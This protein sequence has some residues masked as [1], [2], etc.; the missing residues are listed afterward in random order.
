[1]EAERQRLRQ[2][3]SAEMSLIL[4]IGIR[5]AGGKKKFDRLVRAETN[6]L[7]KMGIPQNKNDPFNTIAINNVLTKL[8]RSHPLD[9]RRN[10]MIL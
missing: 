8:E 2:E 5:Q 1:M 10:R 3:I 4:E 6:R 9:P 7:E